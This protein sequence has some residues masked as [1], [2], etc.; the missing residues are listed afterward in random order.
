MIFGMKRSSKPATPPPAGDKPNTGALPNVMA[1]GL[2]F[3]AS[4]AVLMLEI[5]SVR[6]LT[7]YVGLTLETTTSIIGAVLAG[8]AVGARLGGRAADRVDPRRLVV[9][10][11]IVGGL[12]VLVT[13]PIVHALGPSA[14]GGGDIGALGVTFAALVPVAAVLSAVTPTVARLQLRDLQ[15]SGTVVG[16]LSAWATAGGLVGTFATGFVLVPLFPVSSSVLAI[17]ILLELAGLLLGAY[18]RLLHPRAV[19]GTV[20][21]TL[22]L[23]VLTPLLH[24]PCDAE[25]E[26]HC[27]RVEADP[28]RP[29]GRLLVLDREYNSYVDLQHPTF[30]AFRYTTW[31]GE[32]ISAIGQPKAPLDVVFI[33]AGGF[34]MPY[35]LQAT[36]PGSHS[37]MLEVDGKLVDFDRQHFG[38]R[39]SPDL[40]I[41]IGDARVTMRAQPTHSADVVLGD[42]FSGLTVPW[43]LMTIEWLREVKRVLRPGGLYTLNMNDGRPLSLLRA[44]AATLLEAFRNVRLITPAGADG[45]PKGD[46]AVFLASDGPLPPQHGPPAFG[47]T[48]YDQAAIV[49]LVAGAEALRDDYAP[50]DQLQTKVAQ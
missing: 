12:L 20:L 45:R 38:V 29:T 48:T 25:T 34:T 17:G 4:G 28:E 35:W 13:V 44:E 42:A 19:A 30:L 5:L 49:R 32:A 40:S 16:R 10:L 8:I 31:M 47:A 3:V 43:Q 22:A 24:A 18:V 36:R 1:S 11:M 14:V 2:V 26:Y 33:G 37:H 23:A 15:A 6:L 27:V 39:A 50:V 41:T 46:V 21:A 7:P 9:G